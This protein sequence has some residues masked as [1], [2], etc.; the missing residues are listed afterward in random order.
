MEVII[1]GA[2]AGMGYLLSK[3][4]VPRQRN[5]KFLSNVNDVPDE[6]NPLPVGIRP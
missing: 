3:N 6:A 4:N 1:M 5:I 2:L